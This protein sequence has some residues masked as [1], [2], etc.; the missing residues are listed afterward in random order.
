MGPVVVVTDPA[1]PRLADYQGL[2]D[3]ALR[4]AM[5]PAAG[6]FVAEGALVIERALRAGY[7]LRS[8]LLA[9]R[10]LADLRPV[11]DGVEGDAP[12]YVAAPAVLE[13]VT[14]FHVHRGALATFARRPLPPAGE[15]LARALRVVVCEDVNNP[16]NLGAIARSA[17][18][19]GMDALLLDERSC[20]PL[21]RRAIRVSMG[22][23]LAFPH[24]R[25]APWPA[26][27]AEVRAAGFRILALTPDPDAVPLGAV[28]PAPG[29]RV[30]L[31]LGAEG[32]GLSAG[33]L[34]EADDAVR[35]PMVAG[36]DS[37]NVAAAAAVACYVVGQR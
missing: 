10:W 36:V 28:A 33:A 22:E 21:Y 20:D 1:D 15:L 35:I 19:L 25:L 34:A 24:A 14:G 4:R 12:V 30:A 5:E 29:E 26:A 17:A 6:L 13:E 11:I 3:V 31:L 9:E 27:L 37:L 23:V 32:S 16:T 8:V 18:G 2:T 7:P